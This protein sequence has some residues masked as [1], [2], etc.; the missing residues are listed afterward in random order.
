MS[1]NNPEISLNTVAR[2]VKSVRKKH[3][4]ETPPLIRNTDGD[5]WARQI[6][7]NNRER[8]AQQGL[9]YSPYTDFMPENDAPYR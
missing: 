4:T 7:M 5:R 6:A 3:S 2:W 1:K 8:Q 9:K